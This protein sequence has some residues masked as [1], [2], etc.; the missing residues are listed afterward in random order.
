MFLFIYIFSL[1]SVELRDELLEEEPK[2]SN[3]GINKYLKN[4]ILMV[5]YVHCSVS[6]NVRGGKKFPAPKTL[7]SS[8]T[9]GSSDHPGCT[10]DQEHDA[11]VS[12]IIYDV[13]SSL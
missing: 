6:W 9:G 10:Y 8:L 7:I 13:L 1:Q 11:V 3:N 12:T 5:C 2:Q 4:K